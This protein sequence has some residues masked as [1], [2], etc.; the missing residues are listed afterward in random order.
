MPGRFP[1]WNWSKKPKTV[2]MP[3]S[4]EFAS[5]MRVLLYSIEESMYKGKN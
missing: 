3:E 4:A 5:D 1:R 2:T